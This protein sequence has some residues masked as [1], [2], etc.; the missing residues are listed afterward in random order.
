MHSISSFISYITINN[1]STRKLDLRKTLWMLQQCLS[2]LCYWQYRAMWAFWQDIFWNNL[3]D[4][5][6]TKMLRYQKRVLCY[7]KQHPVGTLLKKFVFFKK[8]QRNAALGLIWPKLFSI[9]F[10]IQY[11]SNGSC[12]IHYYIW[13]TNFMTRS[14]ISLEVVKMEKVLKSI[15]RSEQAL[16]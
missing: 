4:R 6:T 3:F 1:K 15:K 8:L 2:S 13:Q 5:T 7:F 9:I 12:A 16:C 14:L 11:F 10:Q